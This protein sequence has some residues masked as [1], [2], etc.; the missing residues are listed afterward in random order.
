MN[1]KIIVTAAIFGLTAVI[2]GAF[3]AHA[4]KASLSASEL[5]A[6]ETAVNYQFYHALALLF[7]SNFSKYR[8]RAIIASY[9]AFTIG[10]ILFSGS[11]YLLS[12]DSLIG[13]NFSFLGPVTPV[14]GLLMILGWLFM[15]LS[16]LKNK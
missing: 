3:G 13:R 4:L 7:L 8:S 14:G 2:F 11:I 5:H 9:W 16:A 15:L 6:W 1:K 12:I 10:L